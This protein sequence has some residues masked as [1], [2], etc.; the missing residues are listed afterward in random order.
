MRAGQ[1][2]LRAV[3][4]FA[5]VIALTAAGDGQTPKPGPPALYLFSVLNNAA[6]VGP[7]TYT[8][9]TGTTLQ[10]LTKPGGANIVP[11]TPQ[12]RDGRF[13]HA[14][15]TYYYSYTHGGG[16]S[17]TIGLIASSDLQNWTAVAAPDWSNLFR[18]GENAIWNGAWW[19][20]N[21]KYYMFFG[22]CHRL[23]PTCRPYFVPFTPA[24]NSF[25]SPHAISFTT[26]DPHTYNIVMSIFRSA[27]KNWALLQTLDASGN[28]VVALA[29]FTSLTHPWKTDW[30]MIGG[31]QRYRESGAAIV[32]PNGHPQVYY[33]RNAGGQ[34]FYTTA[35]GSDP[36][37]ATWSNPQA[38]PPFTPGFQPADWIDVVPISDSETLENIARIQ[39]SKQ[40]A[41]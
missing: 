15:R 1:P 21:G 3:Y 10:P 30:S 16:P 20:E 41:H 27:G 19:N 34:L 37:H 29:S 5:L 17:R 26:K 32:L 28:S 22:V 11:N 33:V 38:I 12:F 14:G 39:N 36:G 8:S 31:Q 25:G 2:V 13:L 18:N 40:L 7:Q 24:T 35:N 9:V 23:V 6:P 4:I